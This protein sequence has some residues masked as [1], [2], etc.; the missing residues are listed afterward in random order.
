MI[1]NRR[2]PTPEEID[3]IERAARR[4]RAETIAGFLVS[5][6]AALKTL[7][8]RGVASLAIHGHGAGPSAR[9]GL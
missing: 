8:A 1:Q 5:A 6:A 7:A 3:A 9:R 4:L 2:Y